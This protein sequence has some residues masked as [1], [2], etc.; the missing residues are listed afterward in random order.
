MGLASVPGLL[1]GP[2]PGFA[3]YRTGR[4]SG[5]SNQNGYGSRRWGSSHALEVSERARYQDTTRSREQAMS[6]TISRTSQMPST[7]RTPWASPSGSGIGQYAQNSE[8]LRLN[9]LPCP[10]ISSWVP[11]ERSRPGNSSS[12]AARQAYETVA[13]APHDRHLRRCLPAPVAPFLFMG[14]PQVGQFADLMLMALRVARTH[15]LSECL[16][17]EWNLKP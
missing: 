4:V 9:V 12:R 11:L 5:Y 14:V 6:T 7:K 16:K 2:P 15:I 8:V 1:G 13:D 17:P 10:G 3:A